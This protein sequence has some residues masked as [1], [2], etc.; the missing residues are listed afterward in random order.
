M[1]SESLCYCYTDKIDDVNVN[2][3]ASDGKSFKYQTK[4]VEEITERLLQP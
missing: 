4:I 3:N 2:D 1:T